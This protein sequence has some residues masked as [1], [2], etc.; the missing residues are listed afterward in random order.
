MPIINNI[1]PPPSILDA[2]TVASVTSS[3]NMASGFIT[4][5][6]GGGGSYTVNTYSSLNNPAIVVSDNDRTVSVKGTLDLNGIDVGSALA[7]IMATLNVIK[8]DLKMESRYPKLK[9][10]YDH[11]HKILEDYKLIDMMKGEK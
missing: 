11:Y 3:I 9:E 8:R 10:A 4:S 5:S 7:D 2:A 1:A 6:G